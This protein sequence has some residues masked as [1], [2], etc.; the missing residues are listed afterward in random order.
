M[1]TLSFW[2]A[3]A[4]AIFN[5]A[6]MEYDSHE[7]NL[8][9]SDNHDIPQKVILPKITWSEIAKAKKQGGRID[10]GRLGLRDK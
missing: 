5:I 7:T 2:G 10:R 3:E 4:G 1:C 6:L 9:K 8:T